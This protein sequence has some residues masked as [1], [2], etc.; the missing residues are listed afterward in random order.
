MAIT[1]CTNG[2]RDVR[3]VR[4]GDDHS[5]DGADHGGD[6]QKA[7]PELHYYGGGGRR[8]SSGDRNG[9]GALGLGDYQR[10]PGPRRSMAFGTCFSV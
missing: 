9:R 2:A 1:E 4:D 7:H 10:D 8:R 5:G 6:L 3:D